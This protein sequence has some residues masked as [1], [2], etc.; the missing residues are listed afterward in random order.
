MTF[1]VVQ[2][3]KGESL[4]DCIGRADAAMYQGKRDGK[5]QIVSFE[6]ISPRARRS[7]AS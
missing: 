7:S 3:L 5:N 6:S 4:D 2:Y 1:G